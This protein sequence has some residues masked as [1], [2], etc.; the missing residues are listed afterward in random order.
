MMISVKRSFSKAHVRIAIL[1]ACLGLLISGCL[2]LFTH[3][4]TWTLVGLMF[5]GVAVWSV[6]DHAMAY[7]ELEDE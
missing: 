6:R 4:K 1:V 7:G 5:T 2:W 3:M